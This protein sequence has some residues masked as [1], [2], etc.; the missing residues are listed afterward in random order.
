MVSVP[1]FYRDFPGYR[2]GIHPDAAFKI[3]TMQFYF[4]GDE[5]QMHLGTSFHIEDDEGF[6]HWKTNEFKPNSAYAFVRSDH[7]WHSVAQM[8]PSESVRNTLALTLYKKGSE[9]R[10]SSDARDQGWAGRRDR[11][12]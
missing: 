12:P 2:I 5:T 6:R 8:G 7:S 3:A 10:S 1:L 9:Y 11:S 4:P